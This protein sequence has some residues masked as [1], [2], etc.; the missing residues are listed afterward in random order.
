M[1][2]EQVEAGRARNAAR[3]RAYQAKKRLKE[4][5]AN[6][7]LSSFP[8]VLPSGAVDAAG[9]VLPV[10]GGGVE[11][12]QLLVEVKQN[13][14]PPKPKASLR[15]RL[16]LTP[17]QTTKATLP[18]SKSKT[19][20]APQQNLITSVL[21]TVTATLIATY[22]RDRI[23]PE[24]QP[25]APTKNEVEAILGPLMNIIGRRVEVA[26]AVSQDT[27]DISN[28]VLCAMAYSVRAY[29]TYVD[30]KKAAELGTTTDEL[31]K[32]RQAEYKK[33]LD[34]EAA[35]Y[36]RDNEPELNPERLKQG[37]LSYQA[38]NNGTGGNPSRVNEPRPVEPVDGP[39]SY[40]PSNPDDARKLRDYEASL[41]GQMFV[42]DRAGRVGL[43]LLPG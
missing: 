23:A 4:Q 22:A 39:I 20:Q 12:G 11:D 43:G 35:D 19:K 37:L 40:D 31:A 41:V 34:K 32:Q 9:N 13:E 3:Q 21:P 17:K 30:I 16:G 27:I 33:K 8:S 24:Y 28:A 2:S 6:T 15:D 36:E 18:V 25:C 26:A 7:T 1:T 29:V 14:I 38:A 5:E 42:R 10:P